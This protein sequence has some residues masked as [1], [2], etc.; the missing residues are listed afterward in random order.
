MKLR[1]Y[2]AARQGAGFSVP[3][4]FLNVVQYLSDSATSSVGLN[5]QCKSF[6]VSAFALSEWLC[7]H[8]HQGQQDCPEGKAEKQHS[9]KS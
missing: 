4:T 5:I 7:F 9:D 8:P 2:F 6:S 1:P 3:E